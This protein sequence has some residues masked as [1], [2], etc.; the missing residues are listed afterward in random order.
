MR[1]L[2]VTSTRI[3]DAVLSTGIYRRLAETHPEARFT[4]ACGVPALG[5]FQHAPGLERLIGVPKRRLGGHW[6]HLWREV[7]G[8][9]WDQVIDLR[10][11]ALA[12]IL[13][14]GSRRVM[15]GGRREG[16]RLDH[17]A[18]LLGLGEVPLPVAWFGEAEA[19]R[20]RALL[21]DRVPVV[22]L[23]PTANWPGKTWPASRFVALFDQL[24]GAGGPLPGAHVAVLA[25]PGEAERAMADAV[26]D[27]L[28]VR[29]RIDLAG[30][31]GLPEAAAVLA[32][33][34]LFVG[35][36]SGL[37]H[38]A[39]ATGT[40]TLGLFGP[41]DETQYGPRGR[42]A[43]AVRTDETAAELLGRARSGAGVGLMDGL[44]VERAFAGVRALLRQQETMPS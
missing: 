10:G 7:V 2:F 5:V 42:R 30:R 27:A 6:W 40:P 28:P 22:A 4:V 11:S 39:A 23:G 15:R 43:L 20:A 41:S 17:L 1:I 12:W 33:V 9:R 16:H 34:Q 44:P 26:L 37:M 35:N 24:A 38:L 31:L 25:G 8:T 19:A 14:A 36:D 3:G 13:R 18:A 29:R 21:P 32:R